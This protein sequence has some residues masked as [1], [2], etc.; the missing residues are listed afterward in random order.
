MSHQLSMAM[1]IPK[2]SV[3]MALATL[4]MGVSD[5]RLRLGVEA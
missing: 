4:A 2:L 3:T 1:T 5:L